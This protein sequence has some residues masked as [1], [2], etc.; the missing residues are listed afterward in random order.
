M[1]EHSEPQ[2]YPPAPIFKRLM[3][4]MYDLFIL[5]A[6]SMGYSALATV[7]M[8]QVLD[9]PNPG[10][11]RPMQEG[12]WFVLGW[13]T[14]IVCFYW[15]FWARAGQTVGMRAWRLK[16]LNKNDALPSHWQCW[17]RMMVSPLS[18]ALFGLGYWW[19]FFRKDRCTLQDLASSTRVVFMPKK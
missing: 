3:A 14:V 15:F 6:L 2:T 5:L 19:G 9:V 11:Y 18:L 8:V 1:S 17:V 10:D 13:L 16:I 7:V 4:L 12:P